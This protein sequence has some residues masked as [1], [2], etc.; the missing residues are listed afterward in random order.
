M[1]DASAAPVGA[2]PVGTAPDTPELR[3]EVLSVG[4]EPFAAIPTLRFHLQVECTGGVLVQSI[5]LTTCIRIEVARRR[6]DAATR[7]RLAD[8]FGDESRWGTTLRDLTWGQ[9]TTTVPPFEGATEVDLSLPCTLD[10]ELG[11]GKYFEALR[12]GEV[13]LRLLFRGT[14]FY[15]DPDQQL[16]AVQIPWDLEA[17]CRLALSSWREL[18]ESYYGDTRWLRIRRSCLERLQAYRA[19]RGLPGWEETIDALLER[20]APA[21]AEEAEWTS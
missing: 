2:A 6:Y 20:S 17:A 8:L 7:T 12:D 18:V 10:L 21:A 9:I 13:P 19:R 14:V 16:R 3:V 1:S 4:P 11:V 15:R 5:L